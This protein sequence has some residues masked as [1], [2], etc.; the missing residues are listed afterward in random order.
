MFF[1]RKQKLK[2][3]PSLHQKQMRNWTIALTVGAV[4]IFAAVFYFLEKY[5]S[6]PGP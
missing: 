4:V 2:R 3:E 1:D 6:R 5:F